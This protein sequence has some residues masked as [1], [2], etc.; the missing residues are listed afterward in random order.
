M[1]ICVNSLYEAICILQQRKRSPL[2]V[3][4][5]E[6]ID[7][8]TELYL[9]ELSDN[10]QTETFGCQ[11]DPFIDRPPTPL[12]VPA[13]TGVDVATEILLYDVGYDWNSFY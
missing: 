8:Q 4:G 7:V 5:R 3:K 9:E 2:P 11:T 10:A 1:N 12:F 13:K 6:H